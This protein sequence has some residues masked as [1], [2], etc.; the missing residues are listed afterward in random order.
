MVDGYNVLHCAML[1]GEPRSEIGWWGEQGRSLLLG[2]IE[3]F[4][5]LGCEG[6]AA[7][8]L[9]RRSDT[10]WSSIWVVFDGPRPAPAAGEG[11]PRIVFA[12]SADQWI[13]SRVRASSEPGEMAV[14]SAD[15][16]L[17]GR[18]RHAGAAVVSPRDFIAHCGA[19][20]S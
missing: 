6:A 16:Q 4:D 19:A 18:C 20:P 5:G 3:N 8:D 13:V 14:V 7:S 17:G 1:G 15:R 2:R 12:P 10:G 9:S 11:G